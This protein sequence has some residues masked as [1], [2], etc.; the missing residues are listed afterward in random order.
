MLSSIL[1]L[2]G[3]ICNP[4]TEVKYPKTYLDLYKGFKYDTWLIFLHYTR[5]Q[6]PANNQG[7]DIKIYAHK[8]ERAYPL[9]GNVLI[10]LLSYKT[11]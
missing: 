5:T 9:A 1:P 4:E 7:K 2:V 8:A 10:N 3:Q 11:T 6:K